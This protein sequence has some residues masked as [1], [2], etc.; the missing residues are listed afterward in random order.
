MVGSVVGQPP[1]HTQIDR[2]WQSYIHDFHLL[3]YVIGLL[4]QPRGFR[5]ERRG[6]KCPRRRRR[7]NLRSL[8]HQA[9]LSGTLQ[10]HLQSRVKEEK[11][12]SVSRLRRST[13]WP[14]SHSFSFLVPSKHRGKG[15]GTLL[16]KLSLPLTKL[17][18]YRAVYYNLVFTDNTYAIRIY[19]KLG[20]KRTGENFLTCRSERKGKASIMNFESQKT[21]DLCKS[22]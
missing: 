5:I 6:S 14:S 11:S 17:L 1:P 4:P 22:D 21:M 8:L 12:N 7:G 9:Q 2:Y 15:I 18:G 16:A 20:F 13:N 19:E 3:S 10:P